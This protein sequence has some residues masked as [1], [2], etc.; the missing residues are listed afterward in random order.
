[1]CP[2]GLRRQA[3]GPTSRIYSVTATATSVDPS[4]RTCPE[5]VPSQVEARSR[6]ASARIAATQGPVSDSVPI[7]CSAKPPV[8]SEAIA[9]QL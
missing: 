3:T 6:R 9:R 4:R 1:M 5:P 7:S 2:A 8:S